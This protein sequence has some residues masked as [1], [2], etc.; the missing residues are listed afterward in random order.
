MKKIKIYYFTILIILIFSAC[1]TEKNTLITRNYHNLTANYNIFFNGDESFKKGLKKQEQSFVDNYATILPVFKYSNEEVASTIAPDMERAIKKASKLISMHSITAKP[2]RKKGKLTKR[3]KKFYNKNEYNKWVDDAYLLIGKS[4]FYKKDFF[5]AENTFN[6]IIQDYKDEPVTYKAR[7][8][9]L[10][11]YIENKDYKKAN[12]LIDAINS[13]KKFPKKLKGEYYAICADFYIKQEMYE[14]A[15]PKLIQ[16]IEKIRKRKTRIRYN[17][18]L[19]QL[20]EEIKDQENAKITFEKVIKMNPPYEMIFNAKL[21]RAALLDAGSG[22]SREIKKELLKMLKDEKNKEYLDQI[23]YV[24]GQIELKENN[25]SL[26][27]EYFKKSASSSVFNTTQKVMSY[28]QLADIY[29]KMPNYQLAKDYYDSATTFITTDYPN[30]DEIIVNTNNLNELVTN[31]NIVEYQ[32]SLQKVAAMSEEER[33]I[34]IDNLIE[35][36]KEEDRLKQEMIDQQQ[37]QR[38]YNENTYNTYRSSL[39]AGGKWYFYNP[40]SISF[41]LNE[42]ERIWGKRKLEDNWRR[43]N[44]QTISSEQELAELEESETDAKSEK[45]KFQKTDR[46]Y[47]LADIPFT[48]EQIEK[49][50]KKIAEALFNAGKVYKDK[51]EDNEQAEITFEKLVKRFPEFDGTLYVYYNLYLINTEQNDLAKADYYKNLIL[52]NYPNSIYVKVLTNPNYIKELEEER[53]EMESFYFE[54]YNLYQ[55]QQYE[56]VIENYQFASENYHDTYLMPKFMFLYS[57]AIGS[58]AELRDFKIVLQELINKYPESDVKNYA[59]D[60]IAKIEEKSFE[61]TTSD[62]IVAD[63]DKKAHDI[64]KSQIPLYIFNPDT[65]HYFIVITKNKIDLNQLK[66]NVTNFIVDYYDYDDYTISDEPLTDNFKV[67]LVKEFEKSEPAFEFYNKLTTDNQVFKEFDSIDYQYFIISANNYNTL[68]KDKTIGDY[69]K[70]FEE[71]YFKE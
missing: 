49:S 1:S 69:K 41:G 36:V 52:R 24:L 37:G 18:I 45:N 19:A 12:E 23:Y 64:K 54:T 50:N 39:S 48:E 3:E 59:A 27:I 44:K 65:T 66:F 53:Q 56:K 6:F 43:K 58:K 26:A 57:L 10:R 32:D 7:L 47:Y 38:S 40:S 2:K 25:K 15:I 60:I 8:W 30:Y 21:K 11:T 9:L 4:S 13:N 22:K 42:F 35:K 28:L 68:V 71:N 61:Q 20:Y 31:L 29:F 33:N 34:L 5:T 67:I 70:F 46:N 51:L 17:Y 16:A 63:E 14:K 62:E 55:N